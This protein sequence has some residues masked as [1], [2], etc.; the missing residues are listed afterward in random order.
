MRTQPN[1][2]K[3]QLFYFKLGYL[4]IPKI[5]SSINL[6]L[7]G[8]TKNFTK[9]TLFQNSWIDF[10]P[11]KIQLTWLIKISNGPGIFF[12]FRF[13][14]KFQVIYWKMWVFFFSNLIR[15]KTAA[16]PTNRQNTQNCVHNKYCTQPH[17]RSFSIKF[18]K[19]RRF[20]LK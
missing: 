11:S 20:K 14:F 4:S 15:I 5:K 19:V 16:T 7:F 9:F 2:C 12:K 1:L 18:R 10:F 8:T 3:K 17:M 13:T 6:D